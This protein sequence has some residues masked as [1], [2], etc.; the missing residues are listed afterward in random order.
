MA[1][2][3]ATPLKT[4]RMQAVIARIDGGAG[5]G[6][7][8]ICSAAF[9]AILATIPLAKPSFTEAN[10]VLT[11]A[12]PPRSDVAADNTGAAAV[13]RIKDSDGTVW[14]NNLT[15]GVGTGDIQLNSTSLSQGQTVTIT[16][17]TITHAP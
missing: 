1:V 16:S 7:L 12:S 8:E 15:V 13:A 6:V 11:M 17:G 9:A 5:P 3:Y 4:D 10:G 2:N 14:V